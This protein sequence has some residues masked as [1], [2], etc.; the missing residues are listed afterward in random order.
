MPEIQNPI[1][2]GFR[3]SEVPWRE[4]TKVYDQGRDLDAIPLRVI[5]RDDLTRTLW[6]AIKQRHITSQY[7]HHEITRAADSI[8]SQVP[9][10][11][12][13]LHSRISQSTGRH[14]NDGIHEG[15]DTF[16]EELL[17]YVLSVLHDGNYKLE[18]TEPERSLAQGGR[19]PDAG[20]DSD[21]KAEQEKR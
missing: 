16:C 7:F 10:D 3:V 2:L 13:D 21:G 15:P 19:P 17:P 8:R 12:R 20:K 18:Y 6:L 1:R 4:E 9:I 5:F 11:P 14:S